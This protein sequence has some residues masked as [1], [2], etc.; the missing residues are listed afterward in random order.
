MNRRCVG[1]E[2]DDDTSNWTCSQCEVIPAKIDLIMKLCQSMVEGQSKLRNEVA[3]LKKETVD[4]K[5]QNVNLQTQLEMYCQSAADIPVV[6]AQIDSISARLPPPPPGKTLLISS[7][8]A[9]DV[10]ETKLINTDV[11]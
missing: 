9:R 3:A 4:L 5:A 6:K 2:D 10:D 1:L 7:S 11:I 8:L